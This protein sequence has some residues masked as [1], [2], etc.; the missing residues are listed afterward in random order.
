MTRGHLMSKD[1][2]GYFRRR[3]MEERAAAERATCA[4]AEIAHREL[5]LR[6]LLRLVLPASH[7]PDGDPVVALPKPPRQGGGPA[8][9]A[10]PEA[11][12]NPATGR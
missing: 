6:Y 9:S 5:S 4:A 3:A 10:E 8:C 2:A 11:R 7:S 12:T 1:N